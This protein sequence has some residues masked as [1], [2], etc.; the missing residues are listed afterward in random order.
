MI[1]WGQ[2]GEFMLYF[3]VRVWFGTGKLSGFFC[4][5]SSTLSF[6]NIAK[7]KISYVYCFLKH[8]V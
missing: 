7:E 3:E 4:V 1:F 5:F 2:S 8:F 6:L